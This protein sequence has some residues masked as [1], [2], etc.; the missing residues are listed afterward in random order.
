[1][2]RYRELAKHGSEYGIPGRSK[3]RSREG[4]C[5]FWDERGL[6]PRMPRK[7]ALERLEP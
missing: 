5:T 3:V 7:V 4:T 1:M 2:S 6:M